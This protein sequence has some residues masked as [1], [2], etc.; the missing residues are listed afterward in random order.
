MANGVFPPDYESPVGLV[1]TLI[2][3]LTTEDNTAD[4]DYVFSDDQITALVGLYE[5]SVRRAAAAAIDAIAVDEALRYRF[6]RTDDLTVDGSK[7]AEV[8]RKRAQALRDEADALDG[9][10]VEDAF[11]LVYPN[12]VGGFVPEAV[13][14]AWGRAWEWERWR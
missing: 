4:T 13:Q 9:A 6:V 5:G 3:D 14:P 11:Q 2:P 7:S 12:G 1:R 10:E 8:L